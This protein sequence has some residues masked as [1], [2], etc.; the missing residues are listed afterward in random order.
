MPLSS[1]PYSDLPDHRFWRKAVAGLPPFAIDPIVDLPFRIAPTDTKPTAAVQRWCEVVMG[2]GRPIQR[3]FNSRG[4]SSPLASGSSRNA[5]AA[6]RSCTPS[7]A[8]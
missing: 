4:A 8:G 2:Q 7:S 1:N 3:S 6:Q 5:A